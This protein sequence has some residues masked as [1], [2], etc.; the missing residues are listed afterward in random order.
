MFLIKKFWN[1]KEFV[2]SK[3][4]VEVTLEKDTYI[5]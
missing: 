3:H 4:A 1:I 2:I 5:G